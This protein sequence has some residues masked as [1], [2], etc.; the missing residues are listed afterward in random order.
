M[1]PITVATVMI[2]PSLLF[3]YTDGSTLHSISARELSRFPVWEGNRVRDDAHVASLCATITNPREVQGPFT[4]IAI[5]SPAEL[6]VPLIYKILDGQHRAA[7]IE[8]YFS[9]HSDAEDFPVLVRRY[10]VAAIPSHD[11]AIQKFREINNAKPMV[12][13]GSSTERLHQIVTALQS[14]F[15]GNRK[16]SGPVFLIRTA[17]N[18]PFLS[19][20]SLTAALV[21]YRIHEQDDISPIKVVEHARKMNT[22]YAENPAAHISVS[23]TASMLDRAVEY[24]FFLGL[25]PKCPWLLPLLR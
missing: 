14:A 3:T 10:G 17:C 23:I 6:G 7:V 2:K 24:N 4:V 8:N 13:T 12:Y 5:P 20:E 11:I 16:T 9:T 18:R 15:I 25:D 1:D 22:L 19:I 21:K